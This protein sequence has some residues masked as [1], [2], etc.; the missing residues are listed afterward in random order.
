[1]SGHCNLTRPTPMLFLPNPCR[2][3]LES[4]LR[5]EPEVL[6]QELYCLDRQLSSLSAGEP[7]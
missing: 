5:F 7:E 1:M 6:L 4:E 3:S 2:D